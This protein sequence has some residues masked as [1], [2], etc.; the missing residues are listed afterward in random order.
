MFG[1]RAPIAETVTVS[2]HAAE[3]YQHR[4]KPG[5]DL[6]AAREELERLRALGEISAQE[7]AW[8]NAAHPAPYYLLIGDAIVLPLLPQRQG[9]GDDHVRHAADA[10]ADTAERQI[11]AQGLARRAQAGGA[12]GPILSGALMLVT[13]HTA[14]GHS[15]LDVLIG[16]AILMWAL[17]GAALLLGWLSRLAHKRRRRGRFSQSDGMS[18]WLRTRGGQARATPGSIGDASRGAARDA[19]PSASQPPRTSAA[20]TEPT[21]VPP[22]AI[23]G[24]RLSPE[25]LE[26][27]G[28]DLDNS[29]RLAASE[30]RVAPVLDTL[31]ADRWLVERQVLV[32]THRVPF[33]ILGETGVF[34]LWAMAGPL[35]WRDLSF[36]HEIAR[37]VEQALPGYTGTV[38]PGVC[39]VSAP[40]IEPRW[41]C[42]PGEPGAWVV[43]LASLIRWLQH[44]GPENGLGVKDLERLRE[45]A[46]PRWGRPVTDVPLSAHIPNIG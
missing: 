31:P 27:L 24:A 34:V 12:A 23:A 21:A 28:Q 3:Q 40:D 10:D 22:P 15:T 33:L 30:A 39:R 20:R 17:A 16:L 11:R 1:S 32:G 5:L 8:L 13:A 35:Q 18:R 43:G 46:G 38:Q 37:H 7:P 42:R 6:T 44:F 14:G 36:F 29:R 45:L 2:A 26:P 41:W 19:A 25:Q 9:W 4:V